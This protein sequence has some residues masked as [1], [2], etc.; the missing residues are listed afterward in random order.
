MP[1][2]YKL[3][4]SLLQLLFIFGPATLMIL[5]LYTTQ[6]SMLKNSKST[7]IM[8]WWLCTYVGLVFVNAVF[9]SIGTL[10]KFISG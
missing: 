10:I 9:W 4:E 7:K 6:P 3:C 5:A 2:Y 8:K 1:D